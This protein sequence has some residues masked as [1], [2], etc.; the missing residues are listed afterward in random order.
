MACECVGMHT[1]TT[2]KSSN[3][4]DKGLTLKTALK[5]FTIANFHFQLRLQNQNY[6]VTTPH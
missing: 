6:L 4:S 2:Q 5:L 3:R 1:H